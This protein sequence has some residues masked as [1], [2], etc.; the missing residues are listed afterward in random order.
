MITRYDRH[1]GSSLPVTEG[2]K[3]AHYCVLRGFTALLEM[4]HIEDISRPDADQKRLNISNMAFTGS[5]TPVRSTHG[6]DMEVKYSSSDVVLIAQHGTSSRQLVA[7]LRD[8]HES[9]SQLK[10][11]RGSPLDSFIMPADGMNLAHQIVVLS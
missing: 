4:R 11:H 8:F 1:Q 2:G 9:N 3:L 10:K 6:G 7:T 5:N